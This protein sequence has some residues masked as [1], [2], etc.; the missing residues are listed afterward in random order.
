MSQ[1]LENLLLQIVLAKEEAIEQ[2]P[3]PVRSKH[4]VVAKHSPDPWGDVSLWYCGRADY[5]RDVSDIIDSVVALA[6]CQELLSGFL[7]ERAL[8]T[9]PDLT[10]AKTRRSS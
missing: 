3:Q 6:R 10:L 5:Q 1:T 2:L 7:Q 9:P 4:W 8:R